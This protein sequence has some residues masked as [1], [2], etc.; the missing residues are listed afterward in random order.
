MKYLKSL[1]FGSCLFLYVCL[2]VLANDFSGK[3]EGKYSKLQIKQLGKE[4]IKFSIV[5]AKA[6]GCTGELKEEIAL[7]QGNKAIYM[8]ENKC[9]LTFEFNDEK[10]INVQEENC[11][12]YHGASCDFVGTYSKIAR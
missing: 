9:R 11:S 6:K 2:P 4:K 1:F 12:I 5:I 7:I 10:K 3:Y 8:D